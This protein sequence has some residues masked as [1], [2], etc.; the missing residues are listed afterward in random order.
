MG[1]RGRVRG[2][3]SRVGS[4]LLHLELLCKERVDE[5]VA[6]HE[7]HALELG[8]NDLRVGCGV[9]RCRDGDG[10]DGR[11]AVKCSR[12]GHCDGGDYARMTTTARWRSWVRRPVS[13]CWGQGWRSPAT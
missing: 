12:G 4:G 2:G 5:L 11:V 1:G 6:L 10:P 8:R 3:V 13:A 9:T 7:A